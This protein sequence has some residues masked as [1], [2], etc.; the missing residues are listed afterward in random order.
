M[1]EE[2]VPYDYLRTMDYRTG[3]SCVYWSDNRGKWVR[4]AF[5]SEPDHCFVQ[6]LKAPE[7]SRF[8]AEIKLNDLGVLETENR[9]GDI[10]MPESMQMMLKTTISSLLAEAHYKIG[11]NGYGVAVRVIQE[12]G[13]T[14]VN[15][16]LVSVTDA[17]RIMLIMR[18]EY[19][20]KYETGQAEEILGSLMQMSDSYEEL[21]ALHAKKQAAVMDRCVLRLEGN[22]ED[23]LLSVEELMQKLYQEEVVQPLLLERM[24]DAGRYFLASSTGK[25]PPMWGQW[26][27]NVN[28]QVCSGNITNM[29]E[30]MNTFFDFV[31]S[32]LPDY[33]INAK[34][35]FGCRGILADIHPDLNNGLLY[36]FSRTYPHQYWIA[37]AGW[38]YNEFWGYY[39]VTGDETFLKERVVPGLK[40][41][42]LFF[43]DYLTDKDENGKYIFYPCWSPENEPMGQS[44][45]TVNAVM[46]IMVCR[47]VLEN[48][49]EAGKILGVH[50]EKETKWK[51]MLENL[52]ILL[53]D[54]D[55]SLKEWAWKAHP[56]RYNHRHVSHHYD[57]WPGMKVNWQET[58]DL[59]K[60][61]LRSNRKRGQQ[62][63]SAHGIMHRL[64][65]A[66]RLKDTFDVTA[67]ITQLFR[68]GFVNTNMTTN[69]FPY[70]MEFPDMLGGMP[71]ALAEMVI[72]SRPGT[73]ELLPA[74][75]D[76][77]KKG[78]L[79]GANLYTYMHLHG[80][81]WD[82]EAG[83]IRAK[84]VSL[85]DQ[86]CYIRSAYD[87]EMLKNGVPFTEEEK[88]NGISFKKGE[89][90][91]I[92]AVLN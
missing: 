29:P 6:F 10:W 76:G 18:V 45:V 21:L 57:V 39:L 25:Y 54:E 92:N 13:Q 68:H 67:H 51:E 75:P 24:F 64:F 85:K 83:Y 11:E 55:G 35:I 37:C 53:M 62:D 40:E 84:M 79:E 56:E 19:R 44:P 49:L 90:V 28:L 20:E 26:N 12:G 61:I 46:D 14:Q 52:P 33:R 86:C 69:H 77:L 70:R 34:R 50:D 78:R 81:E 9:R 36:H 48:L 63:D 59:A 41:I 15:G 66:I 88:L 17:E 30:Q 1:N 74:L 65:T 87:A 47:E 89:T 60:A 22:K 8:S 82:L 72:Y 42:A 2:G 71:A 38:V 73:I 80:L 5:V 58:P 32:K 16:N 3:E 91:E 7:G 31:E 43:E 4:K 27:I 23:E